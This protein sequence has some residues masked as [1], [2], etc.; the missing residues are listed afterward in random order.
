MFEDVRHERSPILILSLKDP[1]AIKQAKFTDNEKDIIKSLALETVRRQR[2]LGSLLL[3]H[4][5]NSIF[6]I[7]NG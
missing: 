4:Y 5:L 2:I 1:D 6:C 7:I 3:Y